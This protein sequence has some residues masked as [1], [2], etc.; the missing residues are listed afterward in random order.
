MGHYQIRS[1]SS[2]LMFIA[3]AFLLLFCFFGTYASLTERYK[4]DPPMY[5]PDPTNEVKYRELRDIPKIKQNVAEL[6]LRLQHVQVKAILY[7]YHVARLL[8]L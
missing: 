2:F 3:S 8:I 7:I 4:R 1:S 6:E 5:C